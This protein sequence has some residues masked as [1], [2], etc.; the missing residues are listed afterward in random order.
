MTLSQLRYVLSVARHLSFGRAA[1]ECGVAQPSLSVQIKKLEDELGATIFD[2]HQKGVRLTEVGERIVK[3]AQT[4]F[5]EVDRLSEIASL[6]QSR[7]N[8]RLRL[9]IIPTVAS[10]LTPYFLG[11]LLKEYPD[12]E[13]HLFEETTENLIRELS[14][15]RLDA[16]I[17]STPEKVSYDLVERVLYYEPFV[18]FAHPKHRF[19]KKSAINIQSLQEENPVLLD[20]THCMRGQ[21]ED[22]CHS[23]KTSKSKVQLEH[24]TLQTL[25]TLVDHQDSYTLLPALAALDLRPEQRKR[26]V[27]EFQS[28]QPH[29]KIGLIFSKSYVKR[30]L[31]EALEAVILAHLPEAVEPRLK[32]KMSVLSPKATHFKTN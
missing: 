5:V 21:V 17:L 30:S 25:I 24:G 23:K 11:P 32:S 1:E 18:L 20:E 22:L 31:V 13:I 2:R 15:G 29:R 4:V 9:G 10:H 27:R 26:Q 16:A 6:H 12:L 3:Q 19:L 28:P 8:G 7:V 14:D